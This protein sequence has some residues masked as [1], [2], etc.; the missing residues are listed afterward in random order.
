MTTTVTFR[1]L[2][3]LDLCRE[4]DAETARRRAHGETLVLSRFTRDG[5]QKQVELVFR[6]KED[7]E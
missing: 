7:E 4:I 3:A 2:S 6:A 5:D 1:S